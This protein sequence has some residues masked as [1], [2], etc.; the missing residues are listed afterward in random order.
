MFI[1]K[2]IIFSAPS[3]A[4]KTT[5][6]RELMRRMPNLEFSI[7]ACSRSPRENEVDGKDYHFIDKEVFKQ[8]IENHEFVEWQEVY[9]GS[10]YGTL[11]SELER[12]ALKNNHL[13]FDVDVLGGVNLKKIFG[14]SALSIFIMPPS[15]EELE[16]RLINRHT[17]STEAIAKR[18]AK[19]K[20][21][22]TFSNQFDKILINSNL[23]FAI[24]EAV[25]IVDK[26]LTK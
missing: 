23:E 16:L 17:D 8:K 3:G 19:A 11:K 2:Y 12:I 5:I 21:E 13:V 15:I 7:S 24:Q 20:Y 9:A 6:V 25:N 18:V 26:F 22:I 1:Q 14:D 4:G 10:Y